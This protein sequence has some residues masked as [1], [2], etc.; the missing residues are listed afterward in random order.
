MR[1]KVSLFLFLVLFLFLLTGCGS[2]HVDLNQD[3]S[4][5]FHYSINANELYNAQDIAMEIENSVEAQNQ[6]AGEEIVVI[7]KIKEK[8]GGIEALIE[9]KQMF[10][11]SN[12]GLFATVKDILIYDPSILEGLEAVSGDEKEPDFSE[13]SQ[14]QDLAV[15]YLTGFDS[16]IETTI[17]VPGKIAYISGGD[18]VKGEKDTVAIDGYETTI[19]YEPGGVGISVV[20]AGVVILII[21]VGIGFFLYKKRKKALLLQL[22]RKV[23]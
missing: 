5:A 9:V 19:I 14:L 3:G 22:V 21:A 7:K 23:N 2:L 16:A 12:G 15:V 18:L 8:D 4:G 11:G 17:S 1:K 20:I 6:A 13:D 10:N